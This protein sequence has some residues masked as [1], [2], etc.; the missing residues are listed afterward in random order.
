MNDQEHPWEKIYR[1][2]GRV[3]QELLPFFA[4]LVADLQRRG[5]RRVL[6]LGCGNG[7][8]LVHLARAGFNVTGLDIS[9]SGLRLARQ[10]LGEEGQPGDMVQADFRS[11]LP[12]RGEAF[13]ALLAIQV[14]HHARLA[15]VRRA[16]AEIHRVLRPQGLALI[17]VAASKDEGIAYEEIEPGTW[18]PQ[19]G[20]EKGLPHHM[21]GLEELGE[22]LS[23]F[24]VLQIEHRAEGKVLAA[25]VEK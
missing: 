3:Y 6:D 24:Q 17:S 20:E 23:A 14:I 4:P 12:L 22:E 15:E 7:R 9:P 18:A 25:F 10:W 19:S 11:P 13:D 8:H 2:Q 5:V 21:F 16:I 1:S